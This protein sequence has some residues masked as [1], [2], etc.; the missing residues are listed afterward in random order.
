MSVS[1]IDF[2]VCSFSLTLIPMK[3]QLNSWITGSAANNPEDPDCFQIPILRTPKVKTPM[4][5]EL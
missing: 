5:P 3:P 4:K 2:P 1:R